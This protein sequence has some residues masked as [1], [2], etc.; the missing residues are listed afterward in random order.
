MLLIPLSRADQI[1]SALVRFDRSNCP[2]LR[3]I[4][5]RNMYYGGALNFLICFR[6]PEAC[7][8]SN[9]SLELGCLLVSGIQSIEAIIDLANRVKPC[10]GFRLVI[11][12]ML[13]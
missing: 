3:D 13:T 6:L 12:N 9:I 4:G 8:L 1:K 7:A 10:L 11:L 5:L 2:T